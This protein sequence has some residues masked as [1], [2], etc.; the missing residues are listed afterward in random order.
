MIVVFIVDLSGFPDFLK[1]RIG[2][3]MGRKI[4]RMKPFDCDLCSVWWC[5][6]IYLL[7]TGHF[8]LGWIAVVAGLAFMAETLKNVILMIQDM[9]VKLINLIYKFLKL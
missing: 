6:I 4:V 2:K 5:G 7:I 1:Q 3:M 9:V 8:T